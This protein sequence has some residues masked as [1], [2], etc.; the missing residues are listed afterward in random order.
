MR[1]LA[2]WWENPAG[3]S[4]HSGRR[5]S[6]GHL[7]RTRVD[8]CRC[9]DGHL[10]RGQDECSVGAMRTRLEGGKGARADG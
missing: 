8:L 9:C 7:A 10:W 6:A 5:G 1:G 3:R 4:S 2:V